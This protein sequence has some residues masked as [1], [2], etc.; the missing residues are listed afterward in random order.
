MP[1][2]KVTKP[3][4]PVTFK[5]P[6]CGATTR[7]DVAAGGVA[8]EHCGYTARPEAQRVGR[9][10]EEFEFT[11]DTWNQAQAGWGVDRQELFCE[12]CG[13]V[14]SLGEGTLT[15]TCMFCAS[16]RVHVREPAAETLRPRYL[17]PFKV[18]KEM[19]R[20]RAQEW[21][22][23]GWFHPAGLA[24]AAGIERFTGIYVPFWTFDAQVRAKWRAE[25]GYERQERYYDAANKDWKSRTVIDWRW[26]NGEV[27]L[28]ID[29]LLISGSSHLSKMI[30]NRL[31]PYNLNELV[32]YTPDYLAGWQ[33][34]AYDISLPQAWE[35][36]KNLI[37]EQSKQ[38]CRDSIR[39][40]HVR[41]FSMTA[42]FGQETWR[43]LL[44]PV[45]A[46]S[47][48]FEDQVYQIMAN[49]Q[50]G[51]I[52]GQKPVAW[53]KI[54]L[55]IAALFAPGLFL[56]LAGIPLTAMAGVGIFAILFGFIL[57]TAAGFLS[58]RLYKKAA[59]SEAI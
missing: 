10:A 9:Q 42:D 38:A 37:R 51:V 30:L 3:D 50:T 41:N 35:E 57:T 40:S 55:T 13:A 34:T 33:A 48:K 22:G 43:Y 45:Y 8:C 18:Q 32:T 11:L 23:Q 58:V 21:L 54:W 47:Y 31:Y 26:E 52:A 5:C 27:P 14:I 44:L 36:G 24:Q 12:S 29:D 7:Y 1:Q 53:W 20:Q 6:Q 4:I 2:P 17:V 25:V 46:A 56:I 59:A 49:G 16:H 15:A 39:S 19:V 28:T